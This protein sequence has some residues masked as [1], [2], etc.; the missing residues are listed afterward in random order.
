MLTTIIIIP[1]DRGSGTK[2]SRPNRFIRAPKTIRN[3]ILNPT[4]NTKD[5]IASSL[6]APRSC[7]ITKPGTN[8]KKT[9]PYICLKKGI[10]KIIKIYIRVCSASRDI[11]NFGGFQITSFIVYPSGYEEKIFLSIFAIMEDY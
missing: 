3:E 6:S 10:S 1:F 2:L 11:R 8:M 7:R 5:S 9:K 4:D